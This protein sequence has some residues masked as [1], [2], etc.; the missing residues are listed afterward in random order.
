MKA[1]E[2]LK[3][4][5]TTAGLQLSEDQIK[6]LETEALGVELPDELIT[7]ASSKYVLLSE[8]EKRPEIRKNI[9]TAAQ[10]QALEEIASR[11]GSKIELTD[12]LKDG[13]MQGLTK[14]RAI[15]EIVLELTEMANQKILAENNITVDE[16]IKNY[17]TMLKDEKAKIEAL[18]KSYEAQITN[19]KKEFEDRFIDREIFAVASKLPTKFD[20]MDEDIAQAA[21]KKAVTLLLASDN[22]SFVLNNGRIEVIDN[23]TQTQLRKNSVPVSFNDFV[24]RAVATGKMTTGQ[25]KN[26]QN[27]APIDPRRDNKTQQNN[28]PSVQT[29]KD[30]LQ[31]SLAVFNN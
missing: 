25:T 8:A 3:N 23:V 22:A 4:H 2:Y 21:F 20:G 31:K 1:N 6:L 17:E 28:N 9:E 27:S 26:N 11:L 16:R 18:K 7:T 24:E 15:G 19:V 13:L 5:F 14:G 29:F 12:V 10:K 30:S